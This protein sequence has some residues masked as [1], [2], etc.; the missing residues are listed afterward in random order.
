MTEST[1]IDVVTIFPE[2]LEPLNVSLVGK[3]RARGR[4]DVH[5]HDLRSWTHDVHRT[6]DDTPYGGGPGMVMKP[7]P[8][9][10]ALDA[11]LAAGPADQVPTL[12]VPTPSG[13]PFTQE[14]AQELAARPW[15]AF[16]PA[17]YEGIDRRVIE[18][19]ATRMP[20]VETSI[21]DYVLAGGEVAVLVM[22]EAIARL[23]PGVLGNAESHRDDSFAPGAMA[24][25]L[26]GPVYTKPAQWRGREVPE[27][28]LSG[29][30]G[31]IARWRREQAFARTL[32]NRPDLVGRW[33]LGGFDKKERAALAALGLSWD[34]AAGRFRPTAGAVEE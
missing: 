31:L 8:W 15:L 34:E 24:D 30:H 5:L 22:V 13:V 4:L 18:E 9:G 28:L 12:V 23:L 26:E 20:V 16:A 17:R 14:L 29:N 19:A 1:R 21:G 3:A 10:E 6:V 11:V 33:Q 27:V 25:L 32:A 7:E 2:Y